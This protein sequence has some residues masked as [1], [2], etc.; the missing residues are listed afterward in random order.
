MTLARCP[1]CGSE[2]TSGL[3]AKCLLSEPRRIGEYHVWLLDDTGGTAEVFWAE[4]VETEIVGA[5]KLARAEVAARPGGAQ[6][7]REGMKIEASLVHPNIVRV[8]DAGNHKGR[9][10]FVMQLLEGGTLKDSEQLQTSAEPQRVLPLLLKIVRAVAYAQERGVFHCDLKS[11]NILMDREKDGEPLVS[12][13]GLARRVGATNAVGRVS[14]EGGTRG[15]MAPEQIHR[16]RLAEINGGNVSVEALDQTPITAATDVWSLGIL[17]YWLLERTLPF[18]EEEAYEWRALHERLTPL[19]PW[20]WKPA[21]QLRAICH[22]A[23]HKDWTQRYPSAAELLAA[24]ECV[25]AEGVSIPP[26]TSWGRTLL[27]FRRPPPGSAQVARVLLLA[28]LLVFVVGYFF[29][30]RAEE[31]RKALTNDGF[32]A[33]GQAGAALLQLTEY[34]DRIRLASL[35]SAI[36]PLATLKIHTTEPPAVLTELGEVFHIAFVVARDDGRLK[37]QW[38][39]PPLSNWE[40]PYFFRDYFRG[41]ADLGERG[42]SC[43]DRGVG[44][45]DCIYVERALVSEGDGELYF[46]FSTPVF[47]PPA[48]TLPGEP[49]R[50]KGR[51]IGALVG[52]IA[53]NSMLGKV[54]LPRQDSEYTT[55]LIGPRG[56]DR[57][58][59]PSVAALERFVFLVHAGLA[60]GQKMPAPSPFRSAFGK[61]SRPGQQLQPRYALPYLT[62]GYTDPVPGFEGPWNA[63]FAPVGGTGYAVVVQTRPTSLLDQWLSRTRAALE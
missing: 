40:K 61:L 49:A 13:F 1:Q 19:P 28:L 18:G 12:D 54:P 59:P 52:S 9:P 17:L 41:A 62:A 29:R 21:W 24:L 42:V 53:V 63:A 3:C 57:S 37:A 51:W 2:L 43:G 47:E 32:V 22:R 15:W 46:G 11:P 35:D 58:D 20:S 36:A 48:P 50:A 44:T 26:P 10:F 60:R 27:W 56:P 25:E 8:L 55:A 7:F 39:P 5:L 45:A 16:K 30:T 34:A 4:H 14:Y 6:A 33:S 38:P 31:R 23:L